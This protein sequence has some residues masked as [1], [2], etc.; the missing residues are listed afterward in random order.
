MPAP[1]LTRVERHERLAPIGGLSGC[2][3]RSGLQP[4][5]FVVLAE[6]IHLRQA[7]AVSPPIKGLRLARPRRISTQRNAAQSQRIDLKGVL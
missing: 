1:L 2:P 6:D 7:I 3:E 5:P 4:W